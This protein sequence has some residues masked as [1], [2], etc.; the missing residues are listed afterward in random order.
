MAVRQTQVSYDSVEPGKRT[1]PIG[2]MDRCYG[3]D[4]FHKWRSGPLRLRLDLR[5]L[6][7]RNVATQG[8]HLSTF[9]SLMSTQSV[10]H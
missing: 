9:H 6:D 3:G 5:V 4:R 1:T 2:E 8:V 10:M 7:V